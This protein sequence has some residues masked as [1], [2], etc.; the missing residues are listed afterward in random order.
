MVYFFLAAGVVIFIIGLKVTGVVPR[1]RVVLSSSHDALAVMK[2]ADL[3]EDEKERAVRSAA[4]RMFGA[5]FSIL[6]RVSAICLAPVAFVVLFA[7]LGLYSGADALEGLSDWY[8]VTAST[9]VMVA[10]LFV[11]R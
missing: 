9:L 2:A 8:F 4:V 3:D 10:A 7:Y 6:L 11:V 1:V 5:F